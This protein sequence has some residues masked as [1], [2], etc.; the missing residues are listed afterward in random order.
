M[1]HAPCVYSITRNNVTM[2][3]LNTTLSLNVNNLVWKE[4]CLGGI[5]LHHFLWFVFFFSF[6]SLTLRLIYFSPQWRNSP[7]WARGRL[8]FEASRSQSD[9]PHSVG[10]L[11][12]SDQPDTEISAWITHNSHKRQDIP[13][14][15]GIRTRNP[16]KRAAA[17][18]H[19]RP[20]GYWNRFCRIYEE[21]NFVKPLKASERECRF[22]Y[23]V[24]IALEWRMSPW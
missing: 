2:L 3:R 13:A 21:V 11:C 7:Q 24:T 12:T 4:F 23:S 10:L 16:S 19:L 6:L 14:A 18:P 8:I 17:D 15:G 20:R 22:P 5:Q 9:T 1:I